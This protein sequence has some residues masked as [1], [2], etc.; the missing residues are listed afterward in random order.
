MSGSNYCFWAKFLLP[1]ALSILILT[2]CNHEDPFFGRWTVDK[3]NVEFDEYQSTPEMVKQVGELE[4]ENVIEIS[5]DS[6]MSFIS[7]GNTRRGRCHVEGETLFFDGEA[8]GQF[9]EGEIVTE[10]VTPLG[11]VI[12]HYRK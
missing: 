7:E 5:A 4:K 8:F 3:V 10:S 2:S 11:K 1:V 12:V 6:V 9:K